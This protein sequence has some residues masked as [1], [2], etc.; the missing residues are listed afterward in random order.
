M[1]KKDDKWPVSQWIW[2]EQAGSSGQTVNAALASGNGNIFWEDPV[3]QSTVTKVSVQQNGTGKALAKSQT[4]SNMQGVSAANSVKA[5]QNAAK[6]TAISKTSSSGNV[7]ATN[8]NA[9]AN[10]NASN[11]NNNNN[12]ATAKKAKNLTNAKKGGSNAED[13]GNDEFGA[14]CAKAL[15]AHVDVIDGKLLDT[16]TERVFFLN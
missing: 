9:T 15:A 11:N 5:A 13:S 7:T 6:A 10:M 14:W 3:K 16:K 4:V 12:N 8:S 1:A 2:G